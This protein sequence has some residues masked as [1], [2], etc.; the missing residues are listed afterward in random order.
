MTYYTEIRKSS[1][2]IRK[3]KFW[4]SDVIEKKNETRRIEKLKDEKDADG[5]VHKRAT[6]KN[7]GDSIIFFCWPEVVQIFT[8]FFCVN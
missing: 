6:K 5:T 4:E 2:R 8:T 1:V 7:Y 3:A